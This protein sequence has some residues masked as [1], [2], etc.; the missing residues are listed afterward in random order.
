MTV[1]C[2]NNRANALWKGM[3]SLVFPLA[4]TWQTEFFSLYKLTNLEKGK[5]WIETSCTP[6]KIDLCNP[7]LLME[8]RYS[9]NT[10]KKNNRNDKIEDYFENN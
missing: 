2:K 5:F 4:V 7:L 1:L 9:V 10:H 3:N 8:G 6:L